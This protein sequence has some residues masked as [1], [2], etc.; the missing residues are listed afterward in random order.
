MDNKY[1]TPMDIRR[2]ASLV[3]KEV[4][5][6]EILWESCDDADSR[7][8]VALLSSYG[9]ESALL[10]TPY[11][12]TPIPAE[13]NQGAGRLLGSQI[14]VTSSA[15]TEQWEVEFTSSTGFSVTGSSSGAQGAGDV[16]TEF[17]STNERITIPVAAWS[18]KDRI[19]ADDVFRF[20]TYNVHRIL[21]TISAYMA[22][23]LFL[24]TEFCQQS[25][26]AESESD[27]WMKHAE[28][29]LEKMTGE[30]PV[31]KLSTFPSR[32]LDPIG[33]AY[34]IDAYGRDLTNY[35]DNELQ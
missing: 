10:D 5:E 3:T 11:A 13:E 23:A 21:R 1:S 25:P 33:L 7:I 34:N 14:T 20:S 27:K 31:Y 6:D 17:T 28:D 8:V 35:E 9:S 12:S 16:N 4:A 18:H 24:Q 2:I 29:I 32:N 26:N 22:T 15:V 19:Q 30:S